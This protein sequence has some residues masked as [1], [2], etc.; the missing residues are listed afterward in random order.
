MNNIVGRW[1]RFV[2]HGWN[3]QGSILTLGMA[4]GAVV[5]AD[6][7]EAAY[8]LVY[9]VYRLLN[10][11]HA[12]NYRP[13]ASVTLAKMMLD[14]GFVDLGLLTTEEARLLEP[15]ADTRTAK[16]IVLT[17]IARDLTRVDNVKL[18]RLEPGSRGQVLGNFIPKIREG[19]NDFD[20]TFVPIEP[21]QWSMLMTWLVNILVLCVIV[22]SPFRFF[23]L[24]SPGC[25]QV[26][27]TVT[28]L[29]L[30]LSF[31]A[32]LA[33]CDELEDPFD[34][35]MDS[36]NVDGMLSYT[37]VALYSAMRAPFDQPKEPEEVEAVDEDN[38]QKAG[39]D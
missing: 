16:F 36:V 28:V 30:S 14:P 29:L 4:V 27:T 17:W 32:A 6:A 20:N 3:L 24:D 33:M 10:A 21:T 37:N 9:K 26:Q 38:R 11:A 34:E 15:H 25:F 12:L 5:P 2:T 13:L 22:G 7:D 19:M 18:L 35:G 8:K 39:C 31:W 1:Q 23:T